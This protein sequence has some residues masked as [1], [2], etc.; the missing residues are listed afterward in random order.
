MQAV[1]QVDDLLLPVE[2]VLAGEFEVGNVDDLHLADEHRVRDFRAIAARQP[3]RARR[4][5]EPGNDG[6]LLHREGHD[7]FPPIDQ[8][9]EPDAHGQSE[10]AHDVLDHLVGEVRLQGVRARVERDEI[11]FGQRRSVAQR[12]DARTDAKLEETRDSRP[13][14]GRLRL[15][16]GYS[17]FTENPWTRA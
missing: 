3:R 17:P 2:Q 7:H 11:L 14:G 6:G 4:A 8:E 12:G 9:V 16:H 1:G 5:R 15:G 10:D 13:Q